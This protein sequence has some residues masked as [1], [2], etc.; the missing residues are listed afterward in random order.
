MP[1]EP[2]QC[3][4]LHRPS[5]TIYIAVT[6]IPQCSLY[7]PLRLSMNYAPLF[8][9]KRIVNGIEFRTGD[10]VYVQLISSFEFMRCFGLTDDVTFKLSQPQ[11]KFSSDYGIPGFV[12]FLS[13]VTC[14]WCASHCFLGD[15]RWQGHLLRQTD[16]TH[17]EWRTD[18]W[19]LVGLW[20]CYVLERGHALLFSSVMCPKQARVDC[21]HVTWAHIT[22]PVL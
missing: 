9:L 20:Y 21:M 18:I 5:C 19:L 13:D 4:V 17:A 1:M 6:L 16:I 12:Y 7:Q 3:L 2:R 8:V 22:V 15:L 11:F 14:H 10:Q